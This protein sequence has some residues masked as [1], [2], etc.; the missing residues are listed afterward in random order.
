ML[1]PCSSLTVYT[2]VYENYEAQGL[3]SWLKTYTTQHH[4]CR[5]CRRLINS[6]ALLAAVR[7]TRKM[8]DDLTGPDTGGLTLHFDCLA[9][10][11]ADLK[12][13]ANHRQVMDFC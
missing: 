7:V 6:I 11:P 5:N 12:L 13:E 8:T 4:K 1:Q 9:K 2:G 3:V 10:D